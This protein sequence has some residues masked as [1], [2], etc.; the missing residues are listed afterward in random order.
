VEGETG[1]DITV[2]QFQSLFCWI[3]ALEGSKEV[4]IN[5]VGGQFQ[6]LFCWIEALEQALLAGQGRQARIVS[7]LVL[8]D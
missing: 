7:I 6:S 4:G 3:E 1:E 2:W 8:L 5:V